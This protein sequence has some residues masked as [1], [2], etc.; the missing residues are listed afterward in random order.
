MKCT[1]YLQE[2]AGSIFG[3]MRDW[4]FGTECD[5]RWSQSEAAVPG[6]SAL[7][8]NGESTPPSS[9]EV[10]ER[11][12]RCFLSLNRHDMPSEITSL[13]PPLLGDGHGRYRIHIV[14][15]SGKVS[16]CHPLNQHSASSNVYHENK[17]ADV[18]LQE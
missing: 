4:A 7:L 10:N 9:S 15:N 16:H 11:S 12:R 8:A 5:G 2:D 1:I 6:C 13:L 18:C 14:G 3:H 17:D